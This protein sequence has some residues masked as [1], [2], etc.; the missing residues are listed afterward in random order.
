MMHLLNANTATQINIG[1]D[2]TNVEIDVPL[3]NKYN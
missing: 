1:I 3:H 2:V